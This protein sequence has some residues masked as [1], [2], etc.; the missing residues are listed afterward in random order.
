MRRVVALLAL[1]ASYGHCLR[2]SHHPAVRAAA[3]AAQRSYNGAALRRR[4]SSLAMSTTEPT[5]LRATDGAAEPPRTADPVAWKFARAHKESREGPQLCDVND[6]GPTSVRCVA[7]SERY[8]EWQR[9]PRRALVLAKRHANEEE[10]DV[11]AR[12]CA[13][14]SSLDVEVLLADP[15][16]EAVNER[17]AA[18]RWEGEHDA[19]PAPDFVATLGGDGLLLYANTLFQ[20]TAPPPVV[21]FGAGSLG[22][23]AP[24]DVDG[25]GPLEETLDAVGME[26]EPWPVSLRMR[27]RCRVVDQNGGEVAKHEAL[28]EVAIDRGNSP[29]LSA[30]ECYCNDEHLTTAQADGLIVATPTGSTAY[31]LSAG[32]PMVHPSVDAMVF[33]PI[34]PHSLSFRPIVF[35]DS[36]EL[37][38]E[39]APDARADVWVTFD[40]RSRVRLARGDSLVVTASPHPLPTVLRLG[41]TADWFG[42]LRVHFNFNVRRRQKP[43]DPV[44]LNAPEED[45]GSG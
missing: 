5:W 14:L 40:G 38:F 2:Q 11:A 9:P 43:I 20:E 8:V 34:C 39:V 18:T 37:R 1:L 45:G 4:R 31:S 33:T 27:L 32:G 15:L 36:C 29:F 35:P 19:G 13:H 17:V 41:N 22:F 24:F 7:P 6:D 16:Y 26:A 21:A 30:V 3:A 25:D 42:G 23:L 10:L 28:N 12:I 44:F